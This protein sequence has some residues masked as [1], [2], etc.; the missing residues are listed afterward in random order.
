[1][2]RSEAVPSPRPFRPLPPWAQGPA[3]IALHGARRPERNAGAVVHP[4][5]QTSTFRFPGPYSELGIEGPPYLYTR[6]DNPTQEV[7]AETVRLLEGGESARVYGS[8]MGAISAAL[9]GLLSPGEELVA[10]ENLYG[11]TVGLCSGLLRR[12]GIAVRWVSPHEE[13]EPELVLSDRTR[14]VFLESPSNPLLQVHDIAQWAAAADARGALTIVDNTLATPVNQHPIELGADVVVHS[15]TKYLGG[16]SDL[17]AGALVA[18]RSIMDRIHATDIGL[19]SVLDPFAAFLLARGMK[20]LPLRVERQNRSA[21][22]LVEQLVAIPEVER[23]W[24]PGRASPEEEALAARQMGGRS[25]VLAFVLRGGLAAARRTLARL[26][27]VHV[28][29]SFGGVESLV[30]LPE[31]T[32]HVGLSEAERRECGMPSGM[33]RLSVGLEEPEVLLSDLRQA[34][35]SG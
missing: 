18:P 9:L 33:L 4:I 29:S 20:T 30:S 31:E 23:V 19:G 15:G 11:G 12:L 17:M 14:V 6:H 5:Y 21:A 16:H 28:A 24:Y 32:S 7:A 35:G 2:D 3:T 34:I 22:W 1:M 27:C 25:G 13:A 8:G 26:E 10:M